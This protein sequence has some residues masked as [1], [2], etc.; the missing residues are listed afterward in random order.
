VV[1]GTPSYAIGRRSRVLTDSEI[2]RIWRA[3]DDDSAFSLI[4]RMLVWTGCRRSEA[5][6][7]RW[8]E[9]N[10]GGK[11]FS[12]CCIWTVSGTRTKNGRELTLP[13]AAQTTAAIAQWPR[14]L[15]KDTLFGRTSSSGFTTW[16]ASKR[17]LDAKLGFDLAWD[18]HDLRRTTQT[19]M[20]ALGIN[21]DVVNRILNHA[22][23]PIDETY[24]RHTYYDEKA[25]ALQ[26]WADKIDEIAQNVPQ[27]VKMRRH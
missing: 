11:I 23:G 25:H 4:A 6:G 8:G 14:V 7:L 18:V 24:D 3:T 9:F 16:S 12:T 17:A 1:A 10:T 2:A 21:R 27:I 19:R 20:I 22:M 15:G 26:L 5:G 13:L